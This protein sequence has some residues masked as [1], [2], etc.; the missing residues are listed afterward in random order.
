MKDNEDL[1]IIVGDI[2]S[3]VFNSSCKNKHNYLEMAQH[4]TI[5]YLCLFFQ[6][7]DSLFLTY[8][9]SSFQ[10]FCYPLKHD[11]IS[12]KGVVTLPLPFLIILVTSENCFI[13]TIIIFNENIENYSQLKWRLSY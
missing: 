3:V 13:N 5:L 4:E 10:G 7:T 11:K 8:Q 12:Y 2:F 6:N 1:T 9:L